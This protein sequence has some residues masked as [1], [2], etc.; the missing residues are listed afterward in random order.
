M[1]KTSKRG[2][3]I[4]VAFICVLMVYALIGALIN[5]VYYPGARTPGIHFHNASAAPAALAIML[6]ALSLFATRFR[7][8]RAR[9]WVR[10]GLQTAAALAV[11]TALYHVLF[12]AGRQAASTAECVQAYMRMK[13]FA[14]GYA[15][16]DAD[17]DGAVLRV[18][19][20]KA[21]QCEARPMLRTYY[22]C[23]MAARVAT[24]AN[25]CH[26]RAEAL[27]ERPNAS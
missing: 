15:G 17:N 10:R 2:S 9:E 26:G 19:D 3:V 6:Y 22:E 16:N 4:A 12:P 20:E 27:Y 14:V 5:D 24:D 7:L 13:E 11:L 18:F 25:A 21:A 8:S 1:G 23:V